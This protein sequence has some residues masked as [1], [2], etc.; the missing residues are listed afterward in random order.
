MKN[1]LILTILLFASS[2]YAEDKGPYTYEE[3]GKTI[4]A[5]CS[6]AAF[7]YRAEAEMV[8]PEIKKRLEPQ[9]AAEK[10]KKDGDKK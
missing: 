10:A 2:A 3:I 5:L 9:I 6:R 8:C 4:D 1:I 7:G